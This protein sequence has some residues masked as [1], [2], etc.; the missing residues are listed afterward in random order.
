MDK[1]GIG[2]IT[3]PCWVSYGR[4]PTPGMVNYDPR[5]LAF[6]LARTGKLEVPKQC[7]TVRSFSDKE[8]DRT[9]CCRSVANTGL[10][11]DWLFFYFEKIYFQK[12]EKQLFPG[13]PH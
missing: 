8:K 6:I 2:A 7:Q 9:P 5:G 11:C 4:I 1:R 10:A 3:Y 12:L 13:V